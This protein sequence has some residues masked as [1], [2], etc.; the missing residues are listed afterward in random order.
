MKSIIR[1]IN[2]EILEFINNIDCAPDN[3]R[4]V[5]FWFYSDSEQKIYR[6]A[7][8]LKKNNYNI[9]ACDRS[10]NGDFLCIAEQQFSLTE[11]EISRLCVDMQ[12]LAEKMD[13][14]FDGWET[15]IDL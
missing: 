15:R 14:T 5:T 9:V 3:P 2:S 4:P 10:H 6:L 8:H 12:I 1:S 13:I 11:E 7:A